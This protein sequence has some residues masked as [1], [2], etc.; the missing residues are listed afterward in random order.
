MTMTTDEINEIISRYGYS[1]NEPTYEMIMG[2]ITLHIEPTYHFLAAKRHGL[3]PDDIKTMERLKDDEN[4]LF[5]ALRD[6]P[7][8]AEL[9]AKYNW[10]A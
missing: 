3:T 5:Y 8:T 6:V 7:T 9:R 1:S 4:K 2:C 10:A